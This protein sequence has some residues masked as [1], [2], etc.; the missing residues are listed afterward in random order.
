MSRAK[1]ADDSPEKPDG[2]RLRARL[3]ALYHG[4]SV[5]AVRFRLAVLIIDL[6]IIAFFVAAPLLREGGVIFYIID[7]VIAALLAADLAARAW[8]YSDMR[9]WLKKPIVWV[10]LFIL[11]T[12]LF[13]AWLFNLGFLRV[14][15][16]WTL[17]NSD[18]FWRTIG[19]RYDDTRVEEVTKAIV[20]L[21]TFI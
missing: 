7:Y 20:A 18:F 16:L 12:L 19:R 5:T 15:R 9:D 3:R 17:I 13:P 8:A 1:P 4:S 11:A 21:V 14:L 6:I 10:D 2:L